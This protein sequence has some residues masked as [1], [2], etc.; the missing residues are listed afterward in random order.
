[1]KKVSVII[2]CY[3]V[4][5][6]IDTCME[7]LI[8]QTIG[9]ENLE[10]ILVNDAST[11]DSLDKMCEWEQR[12]TDSV[13]V[14]NCT[15]NGKPGKARNI[16]M[17]YATGEFIGFMDDDDIL[18]PDMFTFLYEAAKKHQCDLVT[19]RIAREDKYTPV[20][21][22]NRSSKPDE[23]LA[24][25]STAERQQFLEKDINMSACNKIYSREMLLNNNILFPTG[26]I[27]EDIFFSSLVKHYCQ[28]VYLSERVLYHH[29]ISPSSISENRNKMDR[30]SY[31]EI[32]M[33]LIEELR[34]REFY[35][36]FSKWYEEQFI[37][38]YITF[39]TNYEKLF[40]K[41][42]DALFQIIKNSVWDLFPN[43]ADIPVVKML[44]SNPSTSERIRR[45]LQLQCD[46]EKE[47]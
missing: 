42:E 4:S 1:M 30:I 13:M 40:G 39:V 19:C 25:H 34:K 2:P 36:P 44:L 38:S 24:I 10:I 33:M 14:I 3:N 7:S 12:H 17:Q 29:I 45:V 16:G 15:E 20:S 46:T 41:I 31:I 18:E 32:Y 5:S 23:I 8:C 35:A 43:F 21:N 11:D 9:V 37:I 27:Y 26:M 22:T 6:T 28:K 47:G